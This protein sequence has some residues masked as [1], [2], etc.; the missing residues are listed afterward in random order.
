MLSLFRSVRNAGIYDHVGRFHSRPTCQPREPAG[1]FTRGS[2]VLPRP[3]ISASLV[4]PAR[5]RYSAS[6]ADIT[7]EPSSRMFRCRP[8]YVVQTRCSAAR[9]GEP[10]SCSSAGAS[11][12]PDGNIR[13][14]PNPSSQDSAFPERRC[15][16]RLR[17]HERDPGT[18]RGRG[19]GARFQGPRR[20][21]TLPP[22]HC[23]LNGPNRVSLSPLSGAGVTVKPLSIRTR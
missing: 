23:E 20:I 5:I 8:E 16:R 14:G 1:D 3:P 4:Q 22:R 6:S 11:R 21:F 17:H 15:R 10:R 7:T 2:R 18:L 9:E 19:P 13:R 12:P